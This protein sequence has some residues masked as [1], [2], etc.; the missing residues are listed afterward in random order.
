M[1]TNQTLLDR[2][3]LYIDALHTNYTEHGGRDDGATFTLENK[4]NT[5]YHRIV[6]TTYGSRSV[7]AFVDAEGHLYKSAG[8]KAPAKGA[9]FFLLNDASF[10]DLLAK[11][12]WSGGHLYI[13]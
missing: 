3:E 13:R 4:P 2:I 9:R 6:Q 7:H 8:W 11:A 10:A 12:S 1:I 5:R